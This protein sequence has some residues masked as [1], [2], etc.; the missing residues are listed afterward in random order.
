MIRNEDKAL[1]IQRSMEMLL[2]TASN[3]P[4]FKYPAIGKLLNKPQ[5]IYMMV[6]HVA[7]KIR[8]LKNL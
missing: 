4:Q 2:I 1:S 3:F 5:Y 8:N 6:Y 7:I